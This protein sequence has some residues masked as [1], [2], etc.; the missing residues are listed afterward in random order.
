MITTIPF[1]GFY[2]SLH[3]SAFDYALDQIFS[4]SATGC[5]IN[6]TL[7]W[8]A[9]DCIDWREAHK[10]YAKEYAES[11]AHEFGIDSLKFES[12]SSPKEYNFTTDRI[13]CIIEYADLC[14]IMAGFDLQSFGEY[15]REKFTSRDGFISFYDADLSSWGKVESWDHNQCGTAL[16]FYAM[17]QNSGEF[18]YYQE[19]A[20]MENAQSNGVFD[21]IL[22]DAGGAEFSRLVRLHCYIDEREN[23]KAA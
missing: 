6:E 23:R 1:S 14:R 21:S 11:F 18:D 10:A 17:Q 9:Y 3:S 5:A 22:Y 16:E 13:F 19:W 20:F 7:K 8:K 12:L 15:V 4:D 2:E